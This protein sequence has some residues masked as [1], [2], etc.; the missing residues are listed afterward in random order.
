MTRKLSFMADLSQEDTVLIATVV[1]ELGT[2]IL[3][4]A[5][6]GEI[7][8]SRTLDEGHDAI[9]V[10]AKDQGSGIRDVN[11]AMADHFSTSGTLGMGLPAVHRI[12]TTMSIE[13]SAEQGTRV[14]ASK[15]LNGEKPTVSNL[16][17]PDDHSVESDWIREVYDIGDCV[18]PMQ[19]ERESGDISLIHVH[20]SGLLL[21][22][23]DVSGH[24]P[25]AHTLACRMQQAALKL[26]CSR[27]AVILE[28]LHQEFRGTLGAAVGLA[29]LERKTHKLEFAGVG[30][31]NILVMGRERWRGVCRDGIVGERMNSVFLQTVQLHPGDLVVMASD[32]VS[33][34][35]IQRN[36]SLYA[37]KMSAHALSESV[38]R[39][40]GKALDD[41][42]CLIL[43]CLR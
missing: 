31:I 4:Y 38:I 32:G 33:E 17:K 36:S 34:S 20:P 7:C 41:A 42:S 9:Q 18:R 3:K 40:A 12:M 37:E 21:G 8:V 10:V 24:G 1:S 19:G 11:Q 43:R 35:T 28:S 23:I 39:E 13:S 27:A 25:Q 5:G 15:W 29:T 30:N 26:G 2:N 16:P 14:V 22:L 6:T